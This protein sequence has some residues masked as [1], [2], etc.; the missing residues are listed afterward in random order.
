[1]SDHLAGIRRM[2]P[3][4][5]FHTKCRILQCPSPLSPMSL[6]S[7]RLQ[8]LLNP[9][10]HYG[11]QN[12]RHTAYK[13]LEL[14]KSTRKETVNEEIFLKKAGKCFSDWKDAHGIPTVMKNIHL[15]M[16]LHACILYVSKFSGPRLHYHFSFE[17]KQKKSIW[18]SD[19]MGKINALNDLILLRYLY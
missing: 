1:M 17:K 6:L 16:L 9:Y 11:K 5:A 12:T 10:L 8:D 18:G 2:Q 3:H 15:Q 4:V 19:S 7:P 13:L 14:Q